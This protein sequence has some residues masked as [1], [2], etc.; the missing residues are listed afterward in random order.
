MPKDQFIEIVGTSHYMA[1]EMILSGKY[2]PAVDMWSLGVLLYVCL[3]GLMLL[4]KDDERK[5][6]LLGKKA[7]VGRKLEKCPQLQKRACSDQARN[8]LE[9]M[10]TYDASERISAS[11]ALSHPFILKYCHQFLGG[12]VQAATELDTVIIDKLRRFAKAPKLKKV[13]LLFMAHL[14]EHD[15]QLRD[16]RHNFRTLDK[17]GDGEISR[18]ELEAGLNEAGIAPP[19]DMA[20]I[21]KGCSAHRE[22]KL[23]FVEYL[24]CMMPESLIDERLCHE[25]FSL[26]DPEG[27]GR[28]RAEDLQVVCRHDLDRCRKMVDQVKQVDD[29]SDG[30]DFDDFFTLLCGPMKDSDPADQRPAKHRRTEGTHAPVFAGIPAS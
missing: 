25:A 28:L 6:H 12:A 15:V 21:F 9:M 10:L 22:G 1:P 23:H 8:L 26:L 7:Y 2:S 11:E 4:P 18:E 27:K 3:T 20:E 13:A 17:N 29:G 16:A 24:A 19:P 30:F 5:K 14:A